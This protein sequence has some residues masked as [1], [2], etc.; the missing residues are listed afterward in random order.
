MQ[1]VKQAALGLRSE[2]PGSFDNI[3]REAIKGL[4]VDR[5][6]PDRDKRA[7]NLAKKLDKDLE[8][9]GWRRYVSGCAHTMKHGKASRGERT[10]DRNSAVRVRGHSRKVAARHLHQFQIQ[11]KMLRQPDTSARAGRDER[12][13]V[14]P[15]A[16]QPIHPAPGIEALL[17]R[18]RRRDQRHDDGRRNAER[19]T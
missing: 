15:A 1:I 7:R 5:L 8:R 16:H 17:C 3:W 19:R 10:R 6:L 11:A 4:E 12:A 14:E 2:Q 9:N 13:I 18:C